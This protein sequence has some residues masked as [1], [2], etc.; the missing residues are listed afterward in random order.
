MSAGRSRRLFGRRPVAEVEAE[1]RLHVELL[2]EALV[3]RGMNESDA[4]R[5]A[6]RRMGNLRDVRD[7]CIEID[8]R[9]RRRETVTAM[10]ETFT[11]DIRLAG[12]MF[13]RQKLWTALAVITLGLGIGAN[14]ALFSIVN[15]VLLRPLPFVN[16]DRIM[17]ISSAFDGTDA[18]GVLE[19]TYA[20]WKARE[21][22]FAVFAAYRGTSTVLRG[23]GDPE[24]VNGRMATYGFFSVFGTRPL[25]GRIF[26]A[27]EDQQGS[28]PVV[29]LSEQVWRRLYGGDSSIVGRSI[30]LDQ[31]PATVI[32]VMPAS[33]TTNASAQY[34]IPYRMK[35]P[36]PS[37][38]TFFTSVIARLA[39]GVSLESAHAELQAL[40]PPPRQASKV[41][42]T[43]VVM[44]LHERRFGDTRP[45][46]LMLIAAVGVLLLI[47]CANVANLL[48]ARMARRQREFAV[49]AAIGA[50]SWRLVRFTLCESTLLA[51]M[52]AAVGLLIARVAL[53]TFVRLSPPVISRAEGIAIDPTVALF[54][55]GIALVT[56]VVF[57]LIPAVQVRRVDVNTVLTNNAA[58]MSG[59]TGQKWMR[60]GLVVMEL[61]TALMLVTGAGLLMKS[62]ARVVSIDPG[63]DPSKLAVVTVDLS[64][65]RY[66]E[67]PAV[68]D[69]YRRF[70]DGVKA[71]P[72]VEA[73]SLIDAPP[74]GG[75][76][77]SR[78]A[79]LP[80]G[81]PGVQLDIS[82]VDPDYFRTAGIQIAA[83]RAFDAS[84]VATSE[85]VVILN[86]TA[87]RTWRGGVKVGETM[88][89]DDKTS[90]R[91]VGI[92]RD[93][94]QHGVEDAAPA[95]AYLPMT[96]GGG[97]AHYMTVLAR[98]T[99]NPASVIP[100]IRDVMR[101]LDRQQ[102]LPEIETLERRMSSAVAPRRFTFALLSVF[103]SLGAVLA[104]IGL[105]GV[106]SYLVT[107]RTN[108]IGVRVALGADRRR[109]MRFVVGEGMLLAAAGVTLGL[110]GSLAGVRLLR[111][112][113]FRVSVYDPSIFAAG[114]VLLIATAL[115]A[116]LIPARKAAGLDPVEA[117]RAN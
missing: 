101:R 98:T 6:E 17:S 102:P 48:L 86:E 10:W 67:R 82:A 3:G 52:G 93:V 73:V 34:W 66:K 72:G 54:A 8:T 105:Y 39:P 45:A 16:P 58:R 100:A 4:R 56:G 62:F 40:M 108:E 79:T 9:L 44:T 57:G 37:G 111:T 64:R 83:G 94:L 104:M 51:M 76:R 68:I 23:A 103:A 21:K 106:M 63:M 24:V 29:I 36:A 32:G 110:A 5:E 13:A 112:M 49:R 115:I 70:L 91:V 88:P 15:A 43:P 7:A 35:L 117:L 92:A 27:D 90:L 14:S 81:R 97:P 1:L 80:D 65:G 31:D 22:S 109:I 2:A 99:G 114:A 55:I 95:V 87:A 46:L 75:V 61:A 50:S 38:A 59:S 42:V 11:Q 77:M 89:W 41:T 28:A 85:P 78:R 20:A 96:Q 12:R 26:S 30:L 84:D 19:P 25:L 53:G 60:R 69:F 107:E 113:L 74:L 47:A 18:G 71:I 33:F 116:C